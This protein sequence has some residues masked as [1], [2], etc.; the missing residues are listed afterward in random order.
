MQAILH[1]RT[2]IVI[3]LEPVSKYVT[4]PRQQTFQFRLRV[5][6]HDVER[7]VNLQQG[8]KAILEHFESEFECQYCDGFIQI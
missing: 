2:W 4:A 6:H 8:H 3:A 1:R 7:I 5:D